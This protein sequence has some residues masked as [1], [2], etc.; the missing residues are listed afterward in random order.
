[1]A[2]TQQRKQYIADLA[3]D[4]WVDRL[5]EEIAADEAAFEQMVQ[6]MD[7]ETS[8]FL[9]TT[10]DPQELHLFADLWNWDGGVDE[11]KRVATHPSCDAGTALLIYWR[12]RPEWYLQYPTP[13]AVPESERDTHELIQ[14][15][16]RR[17]VAGK[18]GTGDIA[19][20]PEQT[21]EVGLYK[22]EMAKT[23]R[24]LPTEMYKPVRGAR[25]PE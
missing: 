17:Y 19:Y 21:G 12:A 13:S 5:P 10:T 16:E 11:L 20:D 7:L 23:N 22:S 3:N 9:E 8:R 2:L 18:Y 15:I 4:E 25:R 1:V 24:T 14:T 6:E